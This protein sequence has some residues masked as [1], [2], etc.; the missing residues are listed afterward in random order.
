VTPWTAQCEGSRARLMT[1]S[2]AGLIVGTLAAKA[3][4]K[5]MG[6]TSMKTAGSVVAKAMAKKGIG[7]AG[8]AVRQ[9]WAPPS[10]RWWRRARAPCWARPSAPASAGWWAWAS[11]WWRSPRK[12]S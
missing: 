9:P 1:G 5:A 6:T 2:G 12:K 3:S 10:A 11:T 8:A 4:A 7:R